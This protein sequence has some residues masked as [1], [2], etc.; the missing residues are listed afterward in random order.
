[1]DLTASPC[2]ILQNTNKHD[3]TTNILSAQISN[4]LVCRERK[5]EAETETERERETDRNGE[6]D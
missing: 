6:S 4:W 1:M 3:Y 2:Y 5:R